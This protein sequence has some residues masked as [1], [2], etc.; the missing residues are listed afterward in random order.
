[1]AHLTKTFSDWAHRN[2]FMAV[3]FLP[4]ALGTFAL[5]MPA[6]SVYLHMTQFTHVFTLL[7]LVVVPVSASVAVSILLQAYILPPLRLLSV[8]DWGLIAVVVSLGQWA[9][10]MAVVTLGIFV[11]PA[12]IMDT[13]AGAF[14]YYMV[15]FIGIHAVGLLANMLTAKLLGFT[16]VQAHYKRH[17]SHCHYR[18][19]KWIVL[20]I[21]PTAVAIYFAFDFVFYQFIFTQTGG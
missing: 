17:P 21:V 18:L 20:A 2:H 19:S 1:M 12:I 14:Y 9:A 7:L 10:V 15:P 5:A 16:S 8:W 4:A 3:L 11:L 13:I 6:T